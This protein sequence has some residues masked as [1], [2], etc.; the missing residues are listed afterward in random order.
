[1]GNGFVGISRSHLIPCLEFSARE[2]K[3]ENP[4]SLFKKILICEMAYL[5]LFASSSCSFPLFLNF[6]I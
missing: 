1:M 6:I 4:C 2:M 3:G 5:Y